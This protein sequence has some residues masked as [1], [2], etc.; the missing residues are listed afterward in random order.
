[1]TSGH[2]IG[3]LNS[4]LLH[5]LPT[6]YQ[7]RWR[8]SWGSHCSRC[9]LSPKFPLYSKVLTL[10][11][12]VWSPKSIL[13]NLSKR[14]V[15]WGKG[16]GWGR[17]DNHL[18]AWSRRQA[19]GIQMLHKVFQP[20]LLFSLPSE[21]PVTW[22]S[23]FPGFLRENGSFL[24][25]SRLQVWFSFL[26]SA[27]SAVVHLPALSFCCHLLSRSL[28]SCGF[29][30][31]LFSC[32][33]FTEVSAGRGEEWVCQCLRSGSWLLGFHT[34]LVELFCQRHGIVYFPYRC[35]CD[36]LKWKLLYWLPLHYLF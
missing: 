30:P 16:G 11:S 20:V 13:L 34:S 12:A 29:E 26:W 32:V 5:G 1:M 28:R 24:W 25:L 27:E 23:G 36:V 10:P 6:F 21:G 22:T 8:E 18:T 4:D 19:L 14:P 33:Y 7:L 35:F 15:F 31:L 2:H 9:R 17:G 3:Q